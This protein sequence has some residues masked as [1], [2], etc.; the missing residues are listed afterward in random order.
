M[1]GC[2]VASR[3]SFDGREQENPRAWRIIPGAV[4]A[5][6]IR[7]RPEILIWRGYY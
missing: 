6:V 7:R 4:V 1:D 5:H 2:R 3:T